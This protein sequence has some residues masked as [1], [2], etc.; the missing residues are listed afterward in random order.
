VIAL[1]LALAGSAYLALAGEATRKLLRQT[2]S[3]SVPRPPPPVSLL[4]PLHGDEP[5][6][7]EALA[8][9]LRQDYGGEVQ[10]VLG[11]ANRADPAFAVAERL[12]TAHPELDVT[13]VVDPRRRGANGKVSNLINITPH[14]RHELLVISDSDIAVSPDYLS[15]I[16]AGLQPPEV[17]LVTC[18]YYGVARTGV[19]SRLVAMGITY[20]FLPNVAAGLALGMAR[21]C[22]GSTIALQ[23]ETLQR[24]GG[25]ERFADELA[26][27]YA[28]GAAVR[29]AGL[30]SRVLPVLVEHGCAE[31]SLRALLAHELRWAR[32][33]RGVDP[34]GYIGSGLSHAVAWALIAFLLLGG[35]LAGFVTLGV[36]LGCRIWMMRQVEQATPHVAGAWFLL[37]L[38]DIL[39]FV[40]FVGSFFVRKVEWRGS[41][42]RVD[43]GGGIV[44][45]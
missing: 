27:D 24:I 31:T 38:R 21:P 25:F 1:L 20:Q 9:F 33:I 42:F 45:S 40:V 19:W 29:A 28:L 7:E 5:G 14:G 22:M 16:V 17:G 36:A 15:R 10:L 11:L 32:T 44:R 18:P 26:D 8:S 41:E 43:F 35:G 37:P 4:K 34:A 39:S 12:R 6:L 13:I 3:P 2:E 23:R 30:E